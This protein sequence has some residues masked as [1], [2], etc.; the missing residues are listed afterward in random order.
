MTRE[1]L[2]DSQLDQFLLI[3]LLSCLLCGKRISGVQDALFSFN[4]IIRTSRAGNSGS[5][6]R[7]SS[8]SPRSIWVQVHQD[9][10]TATVRQVHSPITSSRHYLITHNL[11]FRARY[12]GRYKYCVTRLHTHVHLSIALC[13]CDK[14]EQT[15]PS[16]K[17]SSL[18]QS[19]WCHAR[20]HLNTWITDKRL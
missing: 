16:R 8:C 15:Y 19:N 13:V 7:P 1:R 2:K 14:R 3:F 9:M 12:E 5:L 11:Q 20:K 6:A 18:H 4:W 17:R 10:D